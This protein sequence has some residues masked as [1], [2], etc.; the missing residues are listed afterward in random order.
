MHIFLY[1]VAF[2]PFIFCEPVSTF[3][4]CFTGFAPKPVSPVITVTDTR[5]LTQCAT[6]IITYTPVQTIT[7]SPG[8][9]TNTLTFCETITTT[10]P[11][12]TDTFSLTSTSVVTVC[13]SLVGSVS[14][15]ANLAVGHRN[16]HGC[17]YKYS[18]NNRNDYPTSWDYYNLHVL[19]L[20][21]NCLKC[22]NDYTYQKEICALT[23]ARPTCSYGSVETS[24]AG[25]ISEQA[26]LGRQS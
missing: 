14:S 13:T 15:N 16:F 10:L 7:P 26:Q 2:L 4:H 8:T 12:V 24:K 5:I 11:Q 20:Y 6:Q 9:V 21:P 1:I 3:K 22:S 23:E 17:G 18:I 19:R 25:H